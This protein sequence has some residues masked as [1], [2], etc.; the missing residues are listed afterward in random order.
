MRANL[1]YNISTSGGAVCAAA[2]F[3]QGIN[4]MN[5][6]RVYKNSPVILVLIGLLFIGLL[7]AISFGFVSESLWTAIPVA[8]FGIFVFGLIFVANSSKA[9]LSEEEIVTQNLFGRKSLRWSEIGR[10]SGRGYAIKLHNHDEDVTVAPSPGLPGYEEIIE[11]IGRK[12][13]DLFSPQEYSEMKRGLSPF[14]GML[15]VAVLMTGISI[16]FFLAVMDAPDTSLPAFL[17]LLAFVGVVFFFAA[18][19][20]SIPRALTLDGRSLNLKYLFKERTLPADEVRSVQLSY[21]QSRNGKHYFIAL[22]LTSGQTV[23]LSGLGISLPIAYLVLKNWQ[24]NNTQGQIF[25]SGQS[26]DTIA[27]NWSDRSR[28]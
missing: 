21:T 3:N 19:T 12:R 5:E 27:P 22:G 23:R 17:P 10:V 14:I 15:L 1:D 25:N 6:P 9:I 20:F 2:I 28:G 8:V 7:A 24:R 13:P 26:P 16:A 11:I 18:M 4:P